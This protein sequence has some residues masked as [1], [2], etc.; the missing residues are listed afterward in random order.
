MG[1]DIFCVGCVGC[2]VG[3]MRVGVR[4]CIETGRMR[5]REEEEAVGSR[6]A[7]VDGDQSGGIRAKLRRRGTY[8]CNTEV[9]HADH[10]ETRKS[11]GEN[12]HLRLFVVRHSQLMKEAL[13]SRASTQQDMSPVIHRFM[14]SVS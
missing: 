3:R 7:M 2:V 12:L 8:I 5:P 9:P 6:G 1:S 4:T 13:A 14:N 10:Q 11:A